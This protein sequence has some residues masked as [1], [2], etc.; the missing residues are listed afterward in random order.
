MCNPDLK[1]EFNS[2]KLVRE[3]EEKNGEADITKEEKG[4]Y[5]VGYQ[6]PM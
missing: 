1:M 3:E 2:Q 5:K 6:L 4:L